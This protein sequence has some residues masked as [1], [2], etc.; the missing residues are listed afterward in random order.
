M[1]GGGAGPGAHDVDPQTSQAASLPLPEDDAEKDGGEGGIDQGLV[2]LA[3]AALAAEVAATA[4]Q[5]RQ[6]GPCLVTTACPS[7]SFFLSGGGP[8]S[9]GISPIVGTFY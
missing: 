1:G 8:G 6:A 9:L 3:Q 5:L 2:D 4:T 7:S